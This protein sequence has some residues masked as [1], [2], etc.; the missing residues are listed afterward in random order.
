MVGSTALREDAGPHSVVPICPSS[1]TP[2]CIFSLRK[3]IP[4][5]KVFEY[6]GYKLF[7][8]SNEGMPPEPCYIHVR[9][10]EK[11]AK[12]WVDPHV[13]LAYAYEMTSRELINLEKVVEGNTDLI[14]SKWNEHFNRS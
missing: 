4:M 7:F 9:K 11:R 5:P 6:N 8:F 2:A 13:S 3:A 10:A 12:F 14:R 1:G